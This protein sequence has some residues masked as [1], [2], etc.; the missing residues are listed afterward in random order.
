M[1]IEKKEFSKN[2]LHWIL[3]IMIFVYIKYNFYIIYFFSC[4][5]S[6]ISLIESNW[7]DL[8][9]KIKKIKSNSL[10]KRKIK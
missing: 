9:L 7:I 5:D 4:N 8:N 3:E 10:L 1:D 6:E 2:R